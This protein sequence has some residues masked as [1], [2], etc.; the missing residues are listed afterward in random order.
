MI[1]KEYGS[2][3]A[4]GRLKYLNNDMVY[5]ACVHMQHLTQALLIDCITLYHKLI[6]AIEIAVT[7]NCL[8]PH[9]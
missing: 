8:L 7:H 4:L 9:E 1:L 3:L 6:L 5:H 2:L